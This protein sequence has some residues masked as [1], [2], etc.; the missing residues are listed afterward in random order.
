MKST[1]PTE[2]KGAVYLI[3]TFLNLSFIYTRIFG[4]PFASL[5]AFI[6]LRFV[7]KA[8]ND[9]PFT[10]DALSGLQSTPGIQ[11]NGAVVVGWLYCHVD[12][13]WLQLLL[14][15]TLWSYSHCFLRSSAGHRV[16]QVNHLKVEPRTVPLHI[17]T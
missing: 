11:V 17:A 7:G 12:V 10:F 16:F 2:M 8:L 3:Y 6:P 5:S 1:P 14:D 13:H 9:L 4:P 15:E